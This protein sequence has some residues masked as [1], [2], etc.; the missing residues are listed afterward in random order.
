[1]KPIPGGPS[2][3]TLN[4]LMWAVCTITIL[5]ALENGYEGA[6]YPLSTYIHFTRGIEGPYAY[7]ILFPLFAA[8]LERIWPSLSDI[9]AFKA[10]QLVCI[11]ATVYL[12]GKWASLFL[13]NGR[14]L[15]YMLVALML[16][17]TINYWNFYDIALIGFWTG[18]L[19]LL[20]FEKPWAYFLVFAIATLNHENVLLL[21]PT[22]ALY[23]WKRMPM[24][25]LAVFAV[26]QLAVWVLIRYALVFSFPI[27]HV[28]FFNFL[29][30][31]L[32]FWKYYDRRGYTYT[33]V[34]LLPGWALAA[35]GW[36][37]A[38]RILRCAALTLPGLILVTVLFGKFDEARQFDGFIPTCVGLITCLAAAITASGAARFTQT[39]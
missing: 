18:C 9:A 3:R 14:I 33:A 37:Y 5:G 4:I 35:M 34:V 21:V 13:A 1:M 23:F 29:R 39:G 27:P 10:T 25:R 2:M 12:S 15:G 38:P 19:L 22:A 17:P 32:E 6:F 28:I 36:K 30:S 26:G 20:Y 16:A 11:G 24:P 31:N 7:R 8:L